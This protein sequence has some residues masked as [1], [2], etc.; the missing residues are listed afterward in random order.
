MVK[1]SINKNNILWK[2]RDILETINGSKIITNENFPSS[3]EVFEH[4]LSFNQ[5]YIFLRK[6][7]EVAYNSEIPYSS[8][9]SEVYENTSL[10]AK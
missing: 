3:I 10:L 7:K 8:Y 9:L 1:G 4:E 6:H 2:L 5:M